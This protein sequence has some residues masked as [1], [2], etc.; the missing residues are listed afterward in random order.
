VRQLD[1]ARRELAQAVTGSGVDDLSG[2]AARPYGVDMAVGG[3]EDLLADVTLKAKSLPEA[4]AMLR[5][6]AAQLEELNRQLD[7]E[8]RLRK[9]KED[10]IK[11]LLD[12]SGTRMLGCRASAQRSCLLA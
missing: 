4:L 5:R 7:A 8:R 12:V 1:R 2:L 11:R 9:E 6:M 10:E 3:D